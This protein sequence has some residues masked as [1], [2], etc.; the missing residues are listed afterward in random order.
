MN[1]LGEKLLGIAILVLLATLVTVKRTATGTVLDRPT[2][3]PMVQLVNLF[4][5]FF[6][7]IVNPLA[8]AL[9]L[10]GRMA[11][12][13][14]T[15][16]AIPCPWILTG[17]EVV[18]FVLY[19]SGYLLMAASLITLGHKYQ[20]GGSAPRSEDAL[21]SDGPYR[22]IRHPMYT[23]ALSI[24]SG[25]AC[26]TQSGGFC[27]IFIVYLVLILLLIPAEEDG[28]RKAYGARYAAYQG[29][30]RRLIPFVY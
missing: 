6:L 3:K 13:D 18:G 19:V 10:T 9:L 24:S 21:V 14:P 30:A 26:L 25:L 11:D 20:P 1:L 27:C 28:L 12:G 5:L 29:G 2:G 17:S 22:L 4:N 16:V 7:L 8:A 15:H 23:S